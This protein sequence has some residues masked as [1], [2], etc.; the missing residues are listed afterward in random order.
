MNDIS[1]IRKDIIE[2]A[3]EVEAEQSTE[4]V[5]IKEPIQQQTDLS[6]QAETKASIETN[7]EDSQVE[8]GSDSEPEDIPEPSSWAGEMRQAFKTLPKEV[9]KYISERERQ[10][11]AYISRVGGKLGQIQKEYTEIESV[12]KPFE[13]DIKESGLSK[14]QVLERLIS[15]RAEMVKDPRTFIK[16]FADAHNIDLLHVSI[17]AD[18]ADPPEVRK[19][20]WE[21]QTKE[22]AL[23]QQQQ[24]LEAQ[25][26]QIATEQ[27]KT[28]VENWGSQK[29]HFQEVRS[30]MAQVLPEVQ[31]QYPYMSFQEQL[32]VTYSEILKHPSFAN[33]NKPKSVPE[34]VKKAGSGI[35]GYTGTSSPQPEPTSIREALLQAAKETGFL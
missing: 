16:K 11:H 25:Q 34:S 6:Q 31:Q 10:Q 13:N 9:Q 33:L 15:E 5:D 23:R 7:V 3:Q 14:G 26:Q 4:Q 12:L 21:Y 29:P 19:A 18:Q 28:F 17:D 35:N 20:R 27:L 2:S 30:A 1:D 24:Q 22:Q 8:K 32:D